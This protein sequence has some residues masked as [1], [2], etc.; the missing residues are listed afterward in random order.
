MK[1]PIALTSSVIL[2]GALT[3]AAPAIAADEHKV[4]TPSEVAW[5]P[6]PP[7]M[8]KGAQAVT[9][10]GDASKEDLF[11]L[12]IKFPAGFHMPPHSH[13][14]PE[15]VTVISGTFR[16]GN[17]ETADK[18]KTKALPAG[19]FSAM[20]PGMKHYA[21]FDEE[22][23][24]QVNTTGPWGITYVNEKDDPRKTN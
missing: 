15:V 21:Y 24:V 12:R 14:K 17:G 4:F 1:S 10:Y 8:P 7:S 20:S 22:T 3:F 5:G 13:P 2:L 23:V 6:G 16:L 19:S 18:S 9:L 11:V